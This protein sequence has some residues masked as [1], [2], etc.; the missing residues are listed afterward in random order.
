MYLIINGNNSPDFNLALE[1]HALT[2]MDIEA[3]IL[4]RNSASVI[5]GANQN[6]AEE[7]DAEY[8]ASRDI[9]VIRRQSG[10][11]AVFHDPGNVNFTI[12]RDMRRGDFNNYALFT[13][14]I[15]AF[16]ETL[17]VRARLQGR[18]DLVID[19]AKFC[20]NAQAVRRGRIMH[21]GC[22]LYSADFTELSRSLRPSGAKIESHSVKSVRNRV[23]NIADHME[24]PMP[25]EEFFHR[26]ALYFMNNTDDIRPYELTAG[27]IAAT[28]RLV[29][30]KYS[31]WEWN[32]GASPAYNAKREAR[33]EFGTV[34]VRLF[35]ERGII[36]DIRIYGDFF[37]TSDKS[38][39]ENILK[40]A[41]HDRSHIERILSGVDIGEYIKGMTS[42]ELLGMIC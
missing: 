40:G 13:S 2:E 18:N 7:I 20:G 33:Y 26:L 17:G 23:T 28:E 12:I 3:I 34:E 15:I 32:F 10:G 16:L 38:G 22:I 35:V 11:G 36:G 41:R 14:P 21:H 1:E 8:V 37:G 31:K 30:D 25:V 5:I 39:L 24:K 42:D 4:W 19:G 27:D 29:R 9:P 6:T